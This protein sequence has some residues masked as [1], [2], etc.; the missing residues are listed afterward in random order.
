VALPPL[1]FHL[2]LL[3]LKLLPELDL[4]LLLLLQLLL[5]RFELLPQLLLQPPLLLHLSALESYLCAAVL[6][7]VFPK[8]EGLDP[9]VLVWS[10]AQGPQLATLCRGLVRD[11]NPEIRG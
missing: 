9:E 6:L 7:L 11:R 10:R 5:L 2:L 1:R 4:H 8:R 3:P